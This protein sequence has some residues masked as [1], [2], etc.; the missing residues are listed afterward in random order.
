MSCPT[1]F[2]CT[3]QHQ[4]YY[5]CRPDRAP[6]AANVIQSPN[7]S[8]SSLRFQLSEPYSQCGGDWTCYS[9]DV[10]CADAAW[11]SVE[12]PDR[13]T[14][15]RSAAHHSNSHPYRQRRS[16]TSMQPE[17][18]MHYEVVD[19]KYPVVCLVVSC[20]LAS[21]VLTD[22]VMTDSVQA[23]AVADDPQTDT[24]R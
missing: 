22:D 14:C 16:Q 21:C 24:T 10:P 18:N 12:C 4:W 23:P 13:H 8:Q 7:N 1:A 2:T 20:L 3:R 17:P 15:T 6:T 11:E 9:Q 5:Q 19:S